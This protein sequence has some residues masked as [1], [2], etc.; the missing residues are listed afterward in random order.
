MIG[1]TL[2]NFA[3][4]FSLLYGDRRRLVIYAW[5]LTIGTLLQ[6]VFVP[7]QYMAAD[8]WKFG[9]AFSVTWAVLLI[10]SGEQRRLSSAIFL[11]VSVGII[12]LLMGSRSICGLSLA[13]ALYLVL[14]GF[15]RKR[16][17]KGAQLKTG[18]AVALGA[19]IIAG[20]IGIVWSYQYFAGGGF[21]GDKARDKYESQSSGRYGLLLGGRTEMLGYIPAII[22]SP[23]LGHGSW[24]K[25]PKYVIMQH[26]A[27]AILG[28]NNAED[29]SL[30]AMQTGLIPTHSYIFGA[31]V[32]AGV[33]GAF[34]WSWVFYLTLRM[35][36]RVH[37]TTAMLLPFA[38]YAAFGLLWDLLFSPY[39]GQQRIVTPYYIVLLLTCLGPACAKKE[40]VVKKRSRKRR[41]LLPGGNPTIATATHT[42]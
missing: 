11:T 21:L 22:D 30:E 8:P 40:T 35:V 23:I 42:A 20:A 26:Q 6:V 9:Y 17:L 41:R 7:D 4:F 2:M 31:W 29:T 19:S 3:V 33:L 18:A 28:Y 1:L 37:P 39:G 13:T 38:V 10:A 32:D 24:A 5:G 27:L 16:M 25:E 15:A 34:F 12:N 14:T 36:L